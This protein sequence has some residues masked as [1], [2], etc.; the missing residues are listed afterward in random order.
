MNTSSATYPFTVEC[1]EIARCLNSTIKSASLNRA[2]DTTTVQLHN[3]IIFTIYYLSGHNFGYIYVNFNG[4]NYNYTI[5]DVRS[6]MFE[7][8]RNSLKERNINA[9]NGEDS[10]F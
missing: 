5:L 3:G 1:R 8:M 10:G 2:N 4:A 6:M 7:A 9:N